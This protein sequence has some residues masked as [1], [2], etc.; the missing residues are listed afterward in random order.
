MLLGYQWH[1]CFLPSRDAFFWYRQKSDSI[2]KRIW[3]R[4]II[5]ICSL[6]KSHPLW[7]KNGSRTIGLIGNLMN[8]IHVLHVFPLRRNWQWRSCS[9]HRKPLLSMQICGVTFGIKSEDHINSSSQHIK[10]PSL[11]SPPRKRSNN[12]D[13]V[14]HSP[15]APRHP[16]AV[17][18]QQPTHLI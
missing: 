5:L 14:F 4:V 9:T 16:K 17:A 11:A 13:L 12:N 10:L 18:W 8:F 7:D 6:E 2:W 15:H 1:E 3:L